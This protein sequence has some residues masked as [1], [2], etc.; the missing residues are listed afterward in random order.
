MSVATTLPLGSGHS[1][2]HERR[3]TVARGHVK[4]PAPRLDARQLH[5][6]LADVSRRGIDEIRPLAPALG[7]LVPLLPLPVAEL[8]GVHCLRLHISPPD[9]A[10][11]TICDADQRY[12][13]TLTGG[14]GCSSE[15]F[16]ASP[17]PMSSKREK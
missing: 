11:P 8:H 12:D 2:R 15:S 13:H 4:H 9:W 10:V 17:M 14:N 1:R 7:A 6:A 16:P 3:L 5:H